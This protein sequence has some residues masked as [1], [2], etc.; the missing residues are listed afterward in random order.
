MFRNIING[1]NSKGR[2]RFNNHSTLILKENLKEGRQN[3]K[4]RMTKSLEELSSMRLK[5]CLIILLL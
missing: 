3:I 4:S 1:N 2:I 5:A